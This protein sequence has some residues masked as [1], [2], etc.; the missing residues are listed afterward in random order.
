[1][2][3]RNDTPIE[4]AVQAAAEALQEPAA[5]KVV[6]PE[7]V[8]QRIDPPAICPRCHGKPVPEGCGTCMGLGVVS[9]E[10]GRENIP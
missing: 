7:E 2:S 1:M 4:V 8:T 5:V 3:E 9:A 6:V 10:H